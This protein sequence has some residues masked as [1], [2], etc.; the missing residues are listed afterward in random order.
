[1]FVFPVDYIHYSELGIESS[2]KWE[3]NVITH[4]WNYYNG[5]SGTEMKRDATS[6]WQRNV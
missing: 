2:C 6:S 1:M 4:K 5:H 3:N